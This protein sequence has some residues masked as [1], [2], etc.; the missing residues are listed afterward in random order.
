MISDI[1][2]P[3]PLN[4]S[5]SG[6]ISTWTYLAD[7]R[8]ISNMYPYGKSYPVA[9]TYS[10]DDDY[11]YGFNGMEKEKSFDSD[12]DVADFG[13]R[14]FD[15]NYPVFLSRDPLENE[16]PHQSSYV[17]AGNTPILAIDENGERMRAVH[18][19]YVTF[20]KGEYTVEQKGTY[21][22]QDGEWPKHAP[23]TDEFQ[24]LFNGKYYSSLEEVPGYQYAFN[25]QV[26]PVRS[27]LESA[28][29][30]GAGV[31]LALATRGRA[32]RSGNFLSKYLFV[33]AIYQISVSTVEFVEAERDMFPSNL[34]GVVGLTLDV[35]IGNETESI[36]GY[37]ELGDEMLMW[38]PKKIPDE[39]LDKLNYGISLYNVL[40]KA[41]ADELLESM[42]SHIDQLKSTD[43]GSSSSKSSGD[44]KTKKSTP[45]KPAK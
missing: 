12:G 4:V 27:R 38:R 7:I 28:W 10:A 34:G 36:Q 18:L 8:N 9:A 22:R 17:F 31:L 29:N 20:D 15:A 42:K 39:M 11:R 24:Y 1:K 13:A 21:V 2:N 35:A 14:I 30:F 25:K 6:A 26:E 43:S 3:Y 41:T 33:N 32:A 19:F 23:G 37:L 44:K 5:P 45:L 16:F 40:D